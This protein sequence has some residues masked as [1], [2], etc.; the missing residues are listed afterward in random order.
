ML[1]DLL[2]IKILHFFEKK[3]LIT[4]KQL[5]V[6]KRVVFSFIKRTSCLNVTCFFIKSFR[7]VLS[8]CTHLYAKKGC[9]LP[10]RE[11]LHTSPF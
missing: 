4:R 11:H 9:A 6:G 8:Q 10:A 3:N 1:L 2:M 7:W 5:N